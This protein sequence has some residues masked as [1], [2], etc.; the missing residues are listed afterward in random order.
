MKTPVGPVVAVACAG[1]FGLGRP[2]A[3][4]VSGICRLIGHTENLD[5]RKPNTVRSACQALERFD[6]AV[7]VLRSFPDPGEVNALQ[8]LRRMPSLV[9]STFLGFPCCLLQ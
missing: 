5:V 2:V 1:H 4:P 3:S 7:A 6:Q 8:Q 9:I